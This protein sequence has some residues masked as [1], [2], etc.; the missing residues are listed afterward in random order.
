VTI[1]APIARRIS[2]SSGA[3]ARWPGPRLGASE[4]RA[5]ASAHRYP[6]HVCPPNPGWGDGSVDPSPPLPNDDTAAQSGNASTGDRYDTGSA[7][8]GPISPAPAAS[9]AAGV[10]R[11]RIMRARSVSAQRP[12]RDRLRAAEATDMLPLL[13]RDEPTPDSSGCA[14][15]GVTRVPN[16]GH[17]SEKVRGMWVVGPLPVRLRRGL[18]GRPMRLRSHVLALLIVFHADRPGIR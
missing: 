11:S 1:A 4:R 14:A 5:Q 17:E 10:V 7:V 9:P 15:P 16:G 18:S 3:A 12:S 13:H 8:V 6:R 2:F